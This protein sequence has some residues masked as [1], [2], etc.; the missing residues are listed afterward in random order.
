MRVSGLRHDPDRGAHGVGGAS[1]EGI[2]QASD[3]RE[4]RARPACENTRSSRVTVS[5]RGS[6]SVERADEAR[7]GAFRRRALDHRPDQLVSATEMMEH[8][9]MRDSDDAR[10]VLQ[11]DRIG[12]AR[13][14]P[15][16]GGVEDLAPRLLGGAA[17]PRGGLGLAA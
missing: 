4:T 12:S 8:G 7:S 1:P 6:R 9:R 17:A 16:L 14:E 10:H 13:V 3:A 5:V 15:R 2:N 11:S